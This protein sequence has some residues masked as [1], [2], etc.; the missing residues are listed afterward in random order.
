MVGPA[1]HESG[2]R[3]VDQNPFYDFEF[4][5]LH[6]RA[7]EFLIPFAVGRSITRPMEDQT[8]KKVHR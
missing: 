2:V 7:V 4:V 8:M 6:G 3:E 5:G 1:S